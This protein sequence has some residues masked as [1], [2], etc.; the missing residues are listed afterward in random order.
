MHV[1]FSMSH[2]QSCTHAFLLSG[3]PTVS[4]MLSKLGVLAR[5]ADYI[6]LDEDEVEVGAES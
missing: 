6:D 3:A 4:D 1:P 5:A 2:V